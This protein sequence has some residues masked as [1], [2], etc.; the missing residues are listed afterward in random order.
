MGFRGVRRRPRPEGRFSW[1]H[2]I[3]G[4]ER[5]LDI[6]HQ[7]DGLAQFVAQ[8]FTFAQAH[9]MLACGGAVGLDGARHE[10]IVEALSAETPQG[11][12]RMGRKTWWRS[13]SGSRQSLQWRAER[14]EHAPSLDVCHWPIVGGETSYTRGCNALVMTLP[15]LLS[16]R[17]L[18]RHFVTDFRLAS[19]GALLDPVLRGDRAAAQRRR[20]AF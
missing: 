6:P 15:S 19:G 1:V 14:S 9:A 7:R 16:W 20:Y 10:M 4:V 5:A 11:L 17:P 13:A 12:R 2:Q 3:M 18:A 8:R